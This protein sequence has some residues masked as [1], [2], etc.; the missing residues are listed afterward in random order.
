MAVD[1]VDAPGRSLAEGTTSRRT[2][3][4]QPLAARGVGAPDPL[5]RLL[6]LSILAQAGLAVGL[7]L[8]TRQRFPEL[9]PTVTTV[10]LGA[11]EVFEIAGPLSARVHA[12]LIALLLRV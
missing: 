2:T 11:I 5:R 8:V 9:A 7:V 10:V 12:T 6:G 1:S 3:P 4:D